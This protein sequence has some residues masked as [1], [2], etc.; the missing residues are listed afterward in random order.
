MRSV[1]R[2]T[3]VLRW[4]RRLKARWWP[5]QLDREL[6]NWRIINAVNAGDASGAVFR[7]RIKRPAIAS[8]LPFAITVRWSYSTDSRFPSREVRSQQDEFEHA[9]D[10]LSWL[11]GFSE[12]VRV[13]TGNGVKEWLFYARDVSEF[14]EHFNRL[15]E[16]HPE[17]PVTIH[18]ED[19]PGWHIWADFVESVRARATL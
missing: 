16:G 12:L 5:S 18:A 17:Y 10:E 14:G 4:L 2:L 13:A 19:D 9:I 11:N 1:G 8:S 7:L 3:I 6:A 15:L